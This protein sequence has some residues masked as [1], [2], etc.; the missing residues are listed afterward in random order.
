M[1]DEDYEEL[2][3][4]RRDEATVSDYIASLPHFSPDSKMNPRHF[5]VTFWCA[6][7]RPPSVAV[8]ESFRGYN[9]GNILASLAAAVRGVQRG[10]KDE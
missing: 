8:G 6:A 5:T 9:A 10:D 1:T 7:G 3:A 4:R 2:L